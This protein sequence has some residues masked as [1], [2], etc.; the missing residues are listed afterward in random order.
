MA[1]NFCMKH[2]M[3]LVTLLLLTFSLFP[4]EQAGAY[5]LHSLP[6]P[7]AQDVVAQ[8]NALR[9]SNNLPPYQVNTVLMGIAQSHADYIAGTGVVTHFSADGKRP[10]Q[11]A[12]A[13]G[14]SVAGDLSQGGFFS[15]NV[16][17]GID[18]TP[19]DVVNDW[20]SDSD[21]LNT[22]TS[23][24]LKD[25]GVG[26]ALVN[27]VTYYVLDAGASTDDPVAIS[28][29]STLTLPPVL[30][31]PGTQS[32]IVL[33]STPLDN[34]DVYHT[35]QADQALWSIALAYDT[36]IEQLKLLNALASDE[37]FI[38]QKL[39]I[40]RPVVN[41]ETPTAKVTA[42]FGIPTSTATLPVTPTI[43]FTAT[44]LPTPPASPQSGGMVVG[45]IILTALLAAGIGSWLGNKKTT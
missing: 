36:T 42:T 34:G 18:F 44:P 9:A 29:S 31:T 14:Y 15:E 16:N 35:V 22:M 17:S 24:D 38:G 45:I 4:S 28:T 19:A 37:I 5:P 10:Y 8:V 6:N 39:L 33:I 3:A 26:V 27:G 30:G 41:T 20:Q 21:H 2:F 43:T 1:Y 32:A 23:P 12:V 40:R 11:R 13:A 7:S 25:V